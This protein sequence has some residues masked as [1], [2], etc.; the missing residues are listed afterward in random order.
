MRLPIQFVAAGLPAALAFSLVQLVPAQADACGGFF[1]STGPVDQAEESILFEVET[2]G[3]INTVVQVGYNGD[4]GDFSWVI[5]VPEV[6][7][8]DVVP[9]L[10][11]DIL[12]QWGKPQIIGRP[13]VYDSCESYEDFAASGYGC[14]PTAPS[15][16]GNADALEGEVPPSEQE[17]GV[18]IVELPRTGPYDDIVVVSSNDP[19]ELIGWL[20]DNGYIITPAM[21]PLVIEYV[22]EGQKF[23]ALKLAPDVGVQDIQPIKFSCPG[24]FP[25]IP[26]RL[27][28]VA[29]SPD[30]RILVHVVG[31]ER[32]R[33][34]NY[35]RV[36]LDKNM[37]RT[38]IWGWRNNYEA[39]VAMQVDEAG[40]RGFLTEMAGDAAEIRESIDNVSAGGD[41]ESA[42][43][44]YLVDLLRRRPYLTRMYTRMSASEMTDDPSFAPGGADV[45][46][47]IDLSDRG[48]VDA[49]TPHIESEPECGF[50]YCGRNGR[51]GVTESGDEGC[52]CNTGMVAR[53]VFEPTQ[54]NPVAI[55][56][57]QDPIE[58]LIGTPDQIGDPCD[59]FSCGDEG[60][61]LPVNGFPTCSCN[62]GFTAVSDPSRPGGVR[63]D[64]TRVS[65][66]TARLGEEVIIGDPPAGNAEEAGIWQHPSCTS[67]S[68]SRPL[69]LAMLGGLL[70][71]LS[72]RRRRDQR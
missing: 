24:E 60:T 19:Q 62:E 48:P 63:C 69:E 57:C 68:T 13:L 27:T 55:V 28:A 9:A 23:L 35:P 3:T 58:D 59:G 42:A 38:D 70:L 2:D 53:Q 67:S 25:T 20:N 16:A 31:D 18:D 30:M 47:K 5:P 66:D 52:I 33:P 50:T 12:N 37:V 41:D 64:A 61:C 17:R 44:A 11:L 8:I 6:P 32:Y 21:E 43:Q 34:I 22:S 14:G 71:L 56:A 15:Y 49:C 45:E 39:V 54:Q 65:F 4:P 29:A 40:G 72:G 1:C 7:E 46:G 51:C 26:I 10:T 36:E